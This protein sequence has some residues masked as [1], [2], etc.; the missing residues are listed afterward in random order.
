MSDKNFSI[1]IT[2]DKTPKDVYD[3]VNNVRGWWSKEIEGDTDKEGAVFYYHF[4]DIHRCTIKVTE[5]EPGKKVAWRVLNNY[6]NFTKDKT[7]WNDTTIVFDIEKKG[8][9]TELTFTHL[10]LTPVYECYGACSEGWSTYIFK[11]LRD[12]ITTGKGQPN[13]G[14]PRNETEAKLARGEDL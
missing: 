1:S 7:E 13:E 9:E 14:E 8:N 10:G 5:L 12:L 3:A 2:V 11:S 4:R 6:F